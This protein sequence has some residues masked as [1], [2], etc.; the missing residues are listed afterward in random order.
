MTRGS[1]SSESNQKRNQ[2]RGRCSFF[3]V[4]HYSLP[5]YADMALHTASLWRGCSRA[6][7]HTLE[8]HIDQSISKSV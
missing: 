4:P 1:S 5:L 8:H 7:S 6:H 3:L 2:A